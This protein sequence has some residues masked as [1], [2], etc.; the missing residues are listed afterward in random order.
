MVWTLTSPSGCHFGIL[1]NSG[2]GGDFGEVNDPA[3]GRQIFG[4]APGARGLRGPLHEFLGDAFLGESAVFGG[5]GARG[6]GGGV[7]H[8]EIETAG[9]LHTAENAQ[10]IFGEGAAG[11]SQDALAEIGLAAEEVEDFFTDGIV[12]HG[13]DGEIAAGGGFPRSNGRIELGV[14]VAM[15]ASDFTFAAGNGEIA[16]GFLRRC[17]LDDAET[18]A[19]QI[20]ASVVGEN[21][22]QA[23]IGDAVDFEIEILDGKIQQGVADGSPD[24]QVAKAKGGEI[25]GDG[26]KNGWK[27]DGHVLLPLSTL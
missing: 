1:R 6:G 8:G 4:D 5:D 17:E 12:G 25:L 27:D 15:V 16:R 3:G 10:G 14:E 9:E 20:D 26:A 21:F 2:H 7:V 22:G 13:V 24:Q 23:I 18:A 19:D 11:R